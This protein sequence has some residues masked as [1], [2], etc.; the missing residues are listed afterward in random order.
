MWIKCAAC[1]GHSTFPPTITASIDPKTHRDVEGQRCGLEPTLV[2]LSYNT[3]YGSFECMRCGIKNF[4]NITW[5][6]AIDKEK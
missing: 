1:G 6:A 2:M 4:I 3:Y 5:N